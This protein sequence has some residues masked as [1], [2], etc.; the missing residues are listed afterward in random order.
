MTEALKTKLDCS[1]TLLFQWMSFFW[2]LAVSTLIRFMRC[3]YTEFAHILTGMKCKRPPWE[4][5]RA[6]GAVNLKV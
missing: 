5:I 3:P 6:K 4:S 1:L 2:G